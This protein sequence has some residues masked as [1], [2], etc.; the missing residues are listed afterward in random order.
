MILK[1]VVHEPLYSRGFPRMTLWR[2]AR[3]TRCRPVPV[4]TA[5]IASAQIVA[6]LLNCDRP[7]ISKRLTQ[8]LTSL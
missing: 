7:L 8:D 6:A 3:H 2:R 1:T 5:Q 4:A